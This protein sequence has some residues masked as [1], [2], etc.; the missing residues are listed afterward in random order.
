MIAS[1]RTGCDDPSTHGMWSHTT[2]HTVP[3][4]MFTDPIDIATN[5]DTTRTAEDAIMNSV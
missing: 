3:T 2:R 1:W 5:S 4:G